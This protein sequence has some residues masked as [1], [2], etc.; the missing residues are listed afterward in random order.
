MSFPGA[1]GELLAAGAEYYRMDCA[2][3]AGVSHIAGRDFSR[4]SGYPVPSFIDKMF[5][6]T[7]KTLLSVLRMNL[8]AGKLF[9]PAVFDGLRA[10]NKAVRAV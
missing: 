8:R 5:V 7:D 3:R 2:V 10:G 4:K 1:V 9:L 6:S